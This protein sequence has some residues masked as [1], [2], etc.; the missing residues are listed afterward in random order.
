MLILWLNAVVT[1][2]LYA[3]ALAFLVHALR[4]VKRD[5]HPLAG[6]LDSAL[7]APMATLLTASGLH[8]LARQRFLRQLDQ[9]MRAAGA[10]D[11]TR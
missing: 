4:R 6:V 2:T 9:R 8:K 10:T 11:Q 7:S 3:G 5:G 1:L